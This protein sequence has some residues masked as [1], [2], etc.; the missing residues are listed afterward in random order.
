MLI[1]KHEIGTGHC[2][3]V[4]ELSGNAGGSIEEAQRMIDAAQEC[5]ADAVKLQAV[6]PEEMPD[7]EDKVKDCG[8]WDGRK[9]LDV[10]QQTHLSWSAHLALK[11]YADKRG[12]TLFTTVYSRPAVRYLEKYS[13]MPAYKIANWQ[14]GN[15]EL[16]GYVAKTTKPIIITLPGL[17]AW[18]L[19]R[20]EKS[21]FLAKDSL[22]LMEEMA[23]FFGEAGFSNHG[24]SSNCIEAAK[25]GAVM[26]EQHFTLSRDTIDGQFAA[27]PDE[28]KA[29]VK[30]IRG[31]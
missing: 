24:D 4:A 27:M 26:V 30:G 8:K 16:I 15:A 10:Y 6:V 3:I 13:D 2:F 22:T 18:T 20:P 23:D 1:G 5:G 28:F 14:C 11:G 17:D 29:M 25:A 12:I 31:A 7:I 21:I 19:P 9:W